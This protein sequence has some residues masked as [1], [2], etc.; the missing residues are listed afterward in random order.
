MVRLAETCGGSFLLVDGSRAMV[1]ILE[2]DL[3]TR[4]GD[5]ELAHGLHRE[6]YRLLRFSDECRRRK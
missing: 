5:S 4:K 2:A 6:A 1:D 3:D